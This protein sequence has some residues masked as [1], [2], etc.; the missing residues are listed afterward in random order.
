M[1]ELWT[2]HAITTLT[3]LRIRKRSSGKAF[4]RHTRVDFSLVANARRSLA[5]TIP[6]HTM[7]S[8]TSTVFLSTLFL[9]ALTSAQL[10]DFSP[11][12]LPLCAQTCT[13]LAN[14]NSAC[15]PAGDQQACLCQ[16]SSLRS[17][18]TTS[19][20]VCDLFCLTSAERVAVQSWYLSL[21]QN[22]LP[23][24]TATGTASASAAGPTQ[25][26]AGGVLPTDTVVDENGDGVSTTA[27]AAPTG[28]PE[29]E[30]AFEEA[31]ANDGIDATRDYE[32][33]WYA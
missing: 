1:T 18:Y 25:T 20:G 33:S 23:V 6:S 7:P 26:D 3:D 19:E 11:A 5:L 2:T 4:L 22:G 32:G 29:E 21:C 14:A 12:G 9:G 13:T 28:S 16:S 17:L 27:E 24:T 31:I 15:L 30:S 8:V 10:L